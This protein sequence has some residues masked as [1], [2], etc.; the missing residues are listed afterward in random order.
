MKTKDWRSPNP[1]VERVLPCRVFEPDLCSCPRRWEGGMAASRLTASPNIQCRNAS[2]TRIPQGN[3]EVHPYIDPW[4]WSPPL[5][6]HCIGSA[7]LSRLGVLQMCPDSLVSFKCSWEVP[8]CYK[9]QGAKPSLL[10][11]ARGWHQA[12]ARG[13]NRAAW[14]FIAC[15][16]RVWNKKTELLREFR[17]AFYGEG[18][19]YWFFMQSRRWLK[20]ITT[21]GNDEKGEWKGPGDAG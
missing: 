18:L 8:A 1:W 17:T 19:Q 15:P 5:S 12:C 14:D 6:A 16:E 11:C 10:L 21:T 13:G 20:D 2:G 7:G 3:K 9:E 4:N